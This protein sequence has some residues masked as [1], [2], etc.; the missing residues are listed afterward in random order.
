MSLRVKRILTAIIE[1]YI[2]SAIGFILWKVFNGLSERPILITLVAL[3]IFVIK[4][5][6]G[7]SSIIKAVFGLQIVQS[8]TKATSSVVQ[9]LIRNFSILIW[10]LELF[11]MLIRPNRRLGDLLVG[12]EIVK[13]DKISIK[14]Y[15]IELKTKFDL[16]TLIKAVVILVIFFL[17]A[18]LYIS[19]LIN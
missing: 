7:R 2:V 17:V 3:L 9:R 16:I 19:F 13:S 14:N 4:D 6:F 10:P 12:T 15:F 8:K 18:Y 5:S 11:L 1:F